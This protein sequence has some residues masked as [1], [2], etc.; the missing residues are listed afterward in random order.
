MPSTSNVL[1]EAET[2]SRSASPSSTRSASASSAPSPS[3]V[4]KSPPPGRPRSA[5][6]PVARKSAAAAAASA[7]AAPRKRRR[8]RRGGTRADQAVDPDRE[9]PGISASDDRQDDEN[10]AEL[11]VP[12]ARR[13]GE[14]GRVK[15]KGRQYYPGS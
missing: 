8:R 1:D 3:S 2:W 10:Q 6:A 13:P 9:Q 14:R 5:A 4:A 7:A 12:G 11:P 15:K